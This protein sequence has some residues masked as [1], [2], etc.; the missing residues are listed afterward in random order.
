[1]PLRRRK[2]TFT[3]E[4]HPDDL[5]KAGL[6]AEPVRVAR[7]DPLAADAVDDGTWRTSFLL[8][9]RDAEDRRCSDVAVQ[10]TVHGPERSATVEGH[11]DLLGRVRFRMTGPPGT[12]EIEV[13]DVAAGGLAWDPAAGPRRTRTDTAG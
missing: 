12:Y 2:P 7:L 6:F 9:V 4:R 3:V 11:T 1:M 8:E 10:A 13:V 5:P